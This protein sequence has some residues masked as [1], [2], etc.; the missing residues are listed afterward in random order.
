VDRTKLK[1]L[2][3]GLVIRRVHYG[4]IKAKV[5]QESDASDV[6]SSKLVKKQRTSKIKVNLEEKPGTAVIEVAIAEGKNK[7]VRK[8]MTYLGL[9]V[10][11]PL[12]SSK[13]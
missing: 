1:D 13:R 3:T 8:I 11:I 2:E 12:Y 7:E 5:V 4:H 6:G 9:R 10:L